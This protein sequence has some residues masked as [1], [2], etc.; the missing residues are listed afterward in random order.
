MFFGAAVLA[1]VAYR[2]YYRVKIGK[3]KAKFNNM[4]DTLEPG[5][6]ILTF[7]GVLA[8]F[9]RSEGKCVTVLLSPG[10]RVNI[11][12]ESIDSV[13]KIVSGK[14]EDDLIPGIRE[15]FPKA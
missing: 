1:F 6:G 8:T 3:I 15:Y 2:L 5:D 13:Y 14:P 12:R 9:E 11:I 4:V 10:V 7:G